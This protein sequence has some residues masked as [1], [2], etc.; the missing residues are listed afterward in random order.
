LSYNAWGDHPRNAEGKAEFTH[1]M[2]EERSH[3]SSE[4]GERSCLTAFEWLMRHV[5]LW[6]EKV[7]G[8]IA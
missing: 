3:T 5:E 6:R 2:L 1:A 4:P 8:N 7:K